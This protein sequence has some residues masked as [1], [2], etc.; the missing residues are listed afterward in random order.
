MSPNVGV[1]ANLNGSSEAGAGAQVSAA[2]VL[3]PAAPAAPAAPPL[4]PVAPPQPRLVAPAPALPPAPPLQPVAPPHPRLVTPA[5]ALPP[6]P[7]PPPPAAAPA[8]HRVS[9]AVLYRR[10]VTAFAR[11]DLA[12]ARHAFAASARAGHVAAYRALG[13]VYRR[14]GKRAAAIRAFQTY[15]RKAPRSHDA[16]AVSRM[17]AQLEQGR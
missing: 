9:G 11:G 17:V 2:V 15:V 3:A 10:G 4:H 12:R 5:P 13:V 14:E 16:P 7:P 1:L 6:A 8:H